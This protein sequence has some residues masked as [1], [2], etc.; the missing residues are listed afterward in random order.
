MGLL[1]LNFKFLPDR[2]HWGRNS[3]FAA[4]GGGWQGRALVAPSSLELQPMRTFWRDPG[5][6]GGP[7]LLQLAEPLPFLHY[8]F[9]E[10][11]AV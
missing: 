5:I 3:E 2:C 4:T 7:S 10:A 6:A 1:V 9:T 11:T 8:P